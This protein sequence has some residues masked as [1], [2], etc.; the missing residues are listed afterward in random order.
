MTV[1]S[2]SRN[3]TKKVQSFALGSV[4]KR[5]S[6]CVLKKIEIFFFC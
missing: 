5:G 2:E 4:W 3:L 1:P 6:T